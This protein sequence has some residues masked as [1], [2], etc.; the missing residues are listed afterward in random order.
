MSS[1]RIALALIIAMLSVAITSPQAAV[2]TPIA[3]ESDAPPTTSSGIE[4]P[5]EES[6]I[7][8]TIDAYPP[9]PEAPVIVV[10]DEP[11]PANRTDEIQPDI[12]GTPDLETDLATNPPGPG[13][14]A[15]PTT[16]E[17]DAAGMVLPTVRL[18]SVRFAPV[19][20]STDPALSTGV[21]TVSYANAPV[22]DWVLVLAFDDFEIGATGGSIPVSNLTLIDTGGAYRNLPSLNHGE[23]RIQLTD[24]AY[25][26]E[27][28]ITLTF[29]LSIAE[30]IAGSTYHSMVTATA[31]HPGDP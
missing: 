6:A 14:E 16:L 29:Q 23:F 21:I 24:V 11:I 22:A 15:T 13:T 31:S 9:T 17:T 12:T 28:T 26:T 10:V 20:P 7:P 5:L 27:G 1:G 30:P 3:T 19:N 25:A 2:G 4:P 18:E 8:A